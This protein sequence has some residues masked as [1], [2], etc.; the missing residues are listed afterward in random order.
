MYSLAPWLVVFS[1][2]FHI[3]YVYPDHLNHHA[4]NQQ[5]E[6]WQ[7]SGV[8]FKYVTMAFSPEMI[9]TASDLEAEKKRYGSFV[10]SQMRFSATS[11][12]HALKVFNKIPDFFFFF[13]SAES[14]EVNSDDTRHAPAPIIA[15]YYH[16]TTPPPLDR[17][18]FS[19]PEGFHWFRYP[20]NSRKNITQPVAA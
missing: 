20:T 5:W 17:Y 13:S 18:W 12:W 2:F 8:T 6:W 19:S 3:F 1:T 7:F 11:L 4:F 14:R 10:M 9:I 16:I 15:Q